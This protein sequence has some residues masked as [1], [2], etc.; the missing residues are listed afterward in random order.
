MRHLY[1][2]IFALIVLLASAITRGDEPV[3]MKPLF[4]KVKEQR[5]RLR[6]GVYRV[7]GTAT[8]ET[9]PADEADAKPEEQNWDVILF[10]A[11]D[12]DRNL[13]RFDCTS[14]FAQASHTIYCRLADAQYLYSTGIRAL[15]GSRARMGIYGLNEKKLDEMREVGWMDIRALGWA[16]ASGLYREGDYDNVM[17]R[18]LDVEIP[19]SLSTEN[20]IVN[21]VFTQRIGKE[22]CKYQIDTTKGY[23]VARATREMTNL[24]P[25]E[26]KWGKNDIVREIEWQQI[27]DV[28]V[29]VRYVE[30]YWRAVRN[31]VEYETQEQVWKIEWE[32]V[33]KPVDDALFDFK[34]LPAAKYTTVY[35]YRLPAEKVEGGTQRRPVYTFGRD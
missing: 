2:V 18:R 15:R 3:D 12:F 26:L 4:A 35:D 16:N 29:P 9:R 10:G 5:E 27:T 21:A 32:S 33:N 30:M 34:K 13:M 11:F 24:P 8:R 19:K 14:P 20:E 6:S 7:T 31:R 17:E 25:G 1:L 28:W 23:T 22:I